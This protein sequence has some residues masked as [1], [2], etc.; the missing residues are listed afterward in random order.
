[1]GEER[2]DQCDFERFDCDKSVMVIHKAFDVR[3]TS[4]GIIRRDRKTGEWI[5][6]PRNYSKEAW[7]RCTESYEPPK[8]K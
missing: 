7:W 4:K 5:N 2:N 3:N 6:I 1:M 8:K